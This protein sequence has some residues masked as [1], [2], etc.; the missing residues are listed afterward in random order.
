[1][2]LTGERGEEVKLEWSSVVLISKHAVA[3]EKRLADAYLAATACVQADSKEIQELAE[4]LWP[5]SGEIN[6]Y[7][8]NIQ[9]FIGEMEQ[10]KQPRSLDA[11][12]ILMSG[13]NG[14]CTANANLAVALM[15]AKAIP[16]RT[17][18]VIPPTAQRLEMHRIV[19]YRVG[20]QRSYFDPAMLHEAVPMEPWQTVI[21]AKTTLADE[22]VS[23]RPRRSA[24]RGCPYGQEIELRSGGS[25]FGGMISFWTMAKPL[26][27]LEPSK[28]VVALAVED[29]NR[30]LR[31]GN[32]S[33]SQIEAAIAKDAAELTA[34]LKPTSKND[35]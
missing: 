16:S 11:I 8:R 25:R 1:M 10:V 13:M 2:K 31:E 5:K 18:A 19:E 15:R 20:E 3:P 22:R 12:G 4:S 21:M 29:W 26:A 33:A 28:E 24:M 35:R 14:I 30:C 32:L 27:H 23:M 17:M 6:E 7:A 34:A 9:R